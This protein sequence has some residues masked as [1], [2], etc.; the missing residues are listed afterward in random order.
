MRLLLAKLLLLFMIVPL[1]ELVLLLEIGRRVGTPATLLL[2]VG[3]GVTGALLAKR[4]GLGAAR[5]VQAELAAGHVPA[6]TI[7][8]G[9]LIV[10]AAALLITPGVLT[11]IA[12]FLCLVPRTRRMI[13]A[14]LWY[15]LLRAVRQGRA[16]VQVRL[17]QW[18]PDAPH[19]QPT[20]VPA[21]WRR[22]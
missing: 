6:A 4:Q 21:Q 18:P 7:V 12:G 22:E 11:D 2:I 15:A 20:D 17:D 9:L 8:D 14:M 19:E 16:R 13:R 3:T 5:R 1:V 10:V